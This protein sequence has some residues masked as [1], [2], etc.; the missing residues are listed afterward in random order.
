MEDFSLSIII[1][2][3]KNKGKGVYLIDNDN[4]FYLVDEE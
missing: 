1:L 2:F 3:C 4:Q